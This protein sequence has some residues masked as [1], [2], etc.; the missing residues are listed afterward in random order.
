M[1]KA[2]TFLAGH[3]GNPT[4]VDWWMDVAHDPRAPNDCLGIAIAVR[5]L[6]NRYFYYFFSL[7][8]ITEL[9]VILPICDPIGNQRQSPITYGEEPPTSLYAP[10]VQSINQPTTMAN[11][12]NLT[13]SSHPGSVPRPNITAN[14]P[15]YPH[16]Q[17][18]RA[19]LH[20]YGMGNAPNRHSGTIYNQSPP[21]LCLDLIELILDADQVEN[22]IKFCPTKEKMELLKL[23]EA[24]YHLWIFMIL[25]GQQ[26]TVLFAEENRKKPSDMRLRERRSAVL[27]LF[28]SHD[29][30]HRE[31]KSHPCLWIKGRKP[32]STVRGLKQE[33]GPSSNSASREKWFSKSKEF[34]ALL[35]GLAVVVLGRSLSCFCPLLDYRHSTLYSINRDEATWGSYDGSI[36]DGVYGLSRI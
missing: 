24:N 2:V 6:S 5:K 19:G 17:D 8:I 29:G 11:P 18:H 21:M 33:K 36:I 35:H 31:T 20:S 1:T 9:D 25:M 4:S 34:S 14:S 28:S 32:Y 22:L 12:Q 26:M 10:P 7:L 16:N 15:I 27:N 3:A 30:A 23:E 13:G